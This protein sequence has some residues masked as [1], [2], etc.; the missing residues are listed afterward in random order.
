MSAPIHNA[1]NEKYESHMFI[2]VYVLCD[3]SNVTRRNGNDIHFELA[4]TSV[5]SFTI[6]RITVR[7]VVSSRFDNIAGGANETINLQMTRF[8]IQYG[9]ITFVI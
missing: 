1:R 9:N 6:M 2:S 3:V 8:Q 4:V 7:L 5:H